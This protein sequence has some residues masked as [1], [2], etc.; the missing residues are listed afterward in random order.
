MTTPATFAS[1]STFDSHASGDSHAAATRAAWLARVE[2]LVARA[3]FEK[4]G[5]VCDAWF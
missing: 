3:L 2:P 5:D 4:D 1:V